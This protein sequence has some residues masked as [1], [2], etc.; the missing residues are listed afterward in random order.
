MSDLL[1]SNVLVAPAACR[2]GLSRT[3][4]AW[5]RAWALLAVFFVA[6]CSLEA[7]AQTLLPDW[8]QQSPVSTAPQR[9]IHAMTYDAG[10]RQTVLFGG[11]GNGYLND[12]WLWDGS[13][14]TAARPVTVPPPRAAPAMA[15]DAA[16]GQVVLFGGFINA[17][18]R[19][20]DTWLWDGTNWTAT[21]PA[22]SPSPRSN[23]VMVYDAARGQ[24]V[25]FGGFNGS[26]VGETW[27]WNGTNWIN[28]SPAPPALSPSP[29]DDFGMAFDAALG[30]V[31]LFGGSSSGVNVNDT[32]AWNGTTWTPISTNTSPSA[33]DGQGMI[34][35]AA[36]SRIVMF[37]GSTST[38]SSTFLS[39]TWTFDGTNWTQLSA[40]APPAR[41]IPNGVAYDSFRQQAVMFGGLAGTQL[42]DTWQFGLPGNFGNSNVCPAGQASPAPCSRTM[43]FTYNFANGATL[44][45]AR[46]VT[47]GTTGLDFN[48]VAG[49]STCSGTVSPGN[50]SVSVSFTPAAAGTRSGAIQ[51]SDTAGNVLVTTPIYGVG[52]APEVSVGTPSINTLGTGSFAL[53]Q[54]KGVA[55]DAAGNVYVGDSGNQRVVKVAPTGLASTVGVGLGSPQGVAIDGAGTLYVTDNSQNVVHTIP[56]GCSTTACQGTL[57]V[58]LAAGVAVDGAGDVFLT[59]LSGHQVI[60]VPAGCTATACQAAV[61]SGGAASQPAGVAVDAAGNLFIADSGLAKVVEVP[62]G[63]ST[64]ACQIALGTG[65]SRPAGVAVDAAGDLYVADQGLQQL[66][67]LPFGCANVNCEQVFA[68]NASSI[69]VD[70]RGVA[71]VPELTNSRVLLVAQ[72]PTGITFNTTNVGS[73]S[74]DSPKSIPFRNIG[75]QPLVSQ[76]SG[77]TINGP[78][79][80][81][82][83]GPG[84]LPDCLYAFSINPGQACDLA[85]SFRPQSA[86]SQLQGSATFTD[87]A[88]NAASTNQTATFQGAGV[89]ISNFALTVTET[90]SGSGT[91]AD[92]LQQIDCIQTN[93][94]STG[95]CAGS[96]ASGTQVTLIATPSSPSTFLGWGGACASFGVTP[97]CTVTLTQAANA[98]AAFGSQSFGNVNVCPAGQTALAPCSVTSPITFNLAA[99]TSVGSIR[100]VTQG[101]PGLDFT[102][103]TA[104]TCT[105][106]IA[107]GST[108]NVSVRF[109]P[110]APGLRIGAVQLYDT[111]GNLVASTPVSGVGLEPQIAFGPGAQTTLV[112]GLNSPFGVATDAAGDV[113][114]A[115]YGGNQ[116][117]KITPGGTSTSLGQ[118]FS[119][120]SGVAI[121][122]AGNVIVAQ[123]SVLQVP[124][125]CT[126]AACRVTLAQGVNGTATGV[127]TDG[128]GNIFISYLN[129][130]KVIEIPPGCA[131]ASCTS[132]VWAAPAGVTSQPEGIAVNAAGDLFIA[133]GSLVQVL[134]VPAGC[135]T[136]SCQ[137]K[138]GQGWIAP[139][140][141]ALDA[142][143]D[144]FVSDANIA[145]IV[146]V[147]VGCTNSGCQVRII[148][149]SA[150]FGVAVDALGNVI[151]P[152]ITSGQVVKVSRTQPPALSFALTNAGSTSNDSPKPVLVQNGGNQPLTG[153]LSFALGNGFTQITTL[154][155]AAAFPLAPGAVCNET[156]NFSPP[157]ATYFT[158]TATFTDNTLNANAMTQVVALVGTGATNGQAG[159]VA[160]PNVVGQPQIA[161]STPLTGVGLALGTVTSASSNTVP[162]G[163]VISESPGAGTQVTV[164]SAV[165][166]LVST[167]LPQP[168]PP[169]PLSINN[170]YFV[171]GDYVSAGVT[172]RGLGVN[173]KA[174]RS[175]TIPS[176]AQSATQGIPDG[177]D[178]VDAFLYWETVENT[179]VASSASGSFNGYPI[180]GQQIGSDQ[181]GFTDGTLTGT[182]RS[183]R[184]SVNAYLPVGANGNRI[185][186]RAYTVSL[187]DG[188]GSALPLTEGASLVMVY[189]VLSPSFPLKSVVLYDGAAVPTGSAVQVVKGFYDAAGGANG[190]GKNTDLFASGGIWNNS[191]NSVALGAAS[192]YTATLNP[193]SAYA[194]VMLS[195]PVNN[196]DNDGILDAWKAGPTGGA[197]HTG[198]PGYYDLRTGSWVGLPG[199]KHGQKDLFVQLDYMC[200][201]LLADGSCDPAKENLFP[202]PDASG[203]DPL[204]MVKQAFLN[205][206]VQLHLQVGNAVPESTCLDDLSTTPTTLCQFPNQPG[207]IGW[208]NS[209]QFTKLYPRNLQA[210]LTGSDCTT[211]FPFGQ[212]DSYHYV[213]FGHSLAIPAWN[214]RF[215]SLT[216]INVANGV[217]T[218]GT[219]DRG[220][221]LNACPARITLSGVLGDPALNGVYNT[222]GCSD[223]RTI[224]VSTPGVP[225]YTYPNSLLPE[226]VIGLTSGTITSISGYSDLGGADSAV[227]LG[228][229]LTAPNQDM[230]KR[231]NVLAGTLFHEIGHTLGLSHGGL[232]YDTPGSYV[233]TFE[234]NCKPNYQS[235]M[236]YLFQLDLVGPNQSIALSNQTLQ[237]LNESTAAATTQLTDVDGAPATFPTSAWYV[238]Y[239]TGSTVSPATRH[240]DGTPLSGDQA[241]R[242]D[243]SIDP[244]T[245]PWTNGQDLNFIG[246][247]QTSERGFND[248]ANMDLRQLGAT[249]G[250]FVALSNLLYFGSS[251]EPL[252]IGAGGSVTLGSGGKCGAG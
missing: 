192:Q 25:L 182:I 20:G 151:V 183:Y 78:N 130:G 8:Y 55:V 154:D 165:N 93:G 14:W 217:T 22:A 225:N 29:R 158:G 234:G 126:T 197:F 34:Y 58:G 69:A 12:T 195:T 71:Y 143:G 4:A 137:V 142:A 249:S 236:N 152:G 68:I 209:L 164:G 36:T 120:V 3:Y 193:G 100:V 155:C 206:G 239:T 191:V 86:S 229:W 218:I 64:G 189:R 172:L 180:V 72:T 159:T 251:V 16:H 202:A 131:T 237:T 204:A 2:P 66:V 247:L 88:L 73:T 213:L 178:V 132:T 81:Q 219:I 115:D 15:Y 102:P 121:D 238:P 173:G 244:I 83:A 13:N 140:G 31:I 216:S 85:I 109:A 157:S 80:Q 50:C 40:N 70:A 99:T 42:G 233:P 123:T 106:T 240:C 177:A 33:R 92:T 28:V 67:E 246:T 201:A 242:V 145:G 144:V 188:G 226:P 59:T 30:E 160:V 54:P 232:Y 19:L 41:I 96:Y 214:S 35:D 245:P 9:Y 146:E 176:Y 44:G 181:P 112:A 63:C 117:L 203:N 79:F 113:F 223:T 248:I 11:F 135:V 107:G 89:A 75:N 128:A 149:S 24:V 7:R 224:T 175:I 101:T 48:F 187:P 108:C 57:G 163:S 148:T 39:D 23:M 139:T 186:S 220:T 60:E 6:A 199:A 91:V 27:V 10:H 211:R 49:A 77:L 37:G 103:G 111:G 166:L 129:P 200:G 168:P 184:A 230:S 84:I 74:T 171:T 250:E 133:D 156:F 212:K 207:V 95:T 51:L 227:T 110:I 125:G 118:G 194:A 169:N 210:C 1:T 231:S 18:G 105:G 243:A 170:N 53:S 127:A 185:V 147:P 222:T 45:A 138:I 150:P 5:R 97:S 43:R 134:K 114:V 179:P 198:Q 76:G 153:S 104:S 221:G 122:G 141:V 116:I 124:P 87:N 162:S 205:S 38:D 52:Q 26:D 136:T 61:Y 119:S 62:V 46:V 56:A 65:W 241:Y 47:Q 235:V 190:T 82:V 90:G 98:T 196:S 215:G 174:T 17:S 208:K 21:N 161:A 94:A 32:W 167:G 228:L 252:N